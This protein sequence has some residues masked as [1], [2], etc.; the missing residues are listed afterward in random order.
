MCEVFSVL[1]FYSRG[2]KVDQSDNIWV[3]HNQKCGIIYLT[4]LLLSD[5]VF[6]FLILWKFLLQIYSNYV[7]KSNVNDLPL[8]C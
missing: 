2:F 3:W 5:V 1:R 6:V 8:H 4:C 7:M